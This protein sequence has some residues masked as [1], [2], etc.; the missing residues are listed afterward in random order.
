MIVLLL[1]FTSKNSCAK[2]A[3]LFE[4]KYCLPAGQRRKI[5][6]HE[7]G[8]YTAA[9]V[10]LYENR[11]SCGKYGHSLND[12]QARQAFTVGCCTPSYL[13]LHLFKNKCL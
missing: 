10:R 5:L 12:I 7:A 3:K 6:C 9:I 1:V 13:L 4:I 11:V 2:V 8:S